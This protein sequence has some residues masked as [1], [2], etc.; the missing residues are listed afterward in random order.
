M[1]PAEKRSEQLL[2]DVCIRLIELH[3]FWIE[4]LEITVFVE[5]EEGH[6]G[7]ILRYGEINILR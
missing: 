4:Q 2:C 1:I 6:L 7:M 3:Y 5:S